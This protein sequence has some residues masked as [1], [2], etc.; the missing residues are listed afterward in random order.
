MSKRLICLFSLFLGFTSTQLQAYSDSVSMADK[1]PLSGQV[2]TSAQPQ[3]SAKIWLET[4]ANSLLN[5][6]DSKLEVLKS[7]PEALEAF[8]YNKALSFWDS[9]L[10][11]RGLAGRFWYKSSHAMKNNLE[12]QWKWTL[13]RYFL[14]ALPLYDGQ[15]LH[16]NEKMN[17]PSPRRCWLR[18]SLKVAGKGAVDV[19]FYA[20]LSKKGKS[21]GQWKLIDL[22]V[23]GVSMIRHKKGETRQLL[24]EKGIAGLITA[25][26]NKNKKALT[27][28]KNHSEAGNYAH[29]GRIDE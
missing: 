9:Q 13:V 7:N 24:Y 25:L 28:L 2:T 14:K 27:S 16:L 11:A 6:L 10:M 26:F 17:C 23:A 18:T 29:A 21:A 8:F 22:R 15:R 19:D 12:V 5:V 3:L 20:H 1:K 4:E